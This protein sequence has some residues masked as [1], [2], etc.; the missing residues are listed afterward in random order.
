[1][2]K[3]V[4]SM[5]LVIVVIAAASC[6]FL[7]TR[8]PEPI[9]IEYGDNGVISADVCIPLENTTGNIQCTFSAKFQTEEDSASGGYI[10]SDIVE[11]KFDFQDTTAHK[12]N[13]KK[14]ASSIPT[15]IRI[16]WKHKPT[17]MGG[18]P[19]PKPWISLPMV[20]R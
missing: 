18:S 8:E 10:V 20:S 16:H 17:A 6:Y 7:L 2:K 12:F 11:H 5:A 9:S 4:I 3:Y 19:S 13:F 15:C 1:M 14:S